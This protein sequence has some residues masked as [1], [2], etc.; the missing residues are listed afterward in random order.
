M[1]IQY[2]DVNT[3]DS[4]VSSGTVVVDFFS[5][6]CVPCKTLSQILEDLSIN[7][8]IMDIVKV[9]TTEHPELRKRFGIM[10][11]PTLYFY[12]DGILRYS[13]TGVM[14]EEAIAQQVASLLYE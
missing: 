14:E 2:A 4:L 8:P 9:N 5:T 1:A 12:K 3:Y 7:M 6:T 11:V 10:G 13:H